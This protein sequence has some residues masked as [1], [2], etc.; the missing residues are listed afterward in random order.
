MPLTIRN[1]KIMFFAAALALTGCAPEEHSMQDAPK[2]E[3]LIDDIAA[4]T[5]NFF[6]ET[7][8]PENGL[9]PDRYP[10]PSFSSI[11]AVGYGLTAYPIGVERGFIS[12]DEAIDRTLATLRFFHTAPQGPE[13]RGNSGYK[14]FF[15][16]FLDMKTGERFDLTEL[17]TVDTA[18]LLGGVLFAQS[19]FDADTPREAEIRQL[20]EEIY[21]RTDWQWAMARPPLISLGWHPEKGFIPWD[22]RGYNEAMLVYILALGSPT[23]GIDEAAWDEWTS[24]Y[25]DSWGTLYGQSYLQFPSQFGHQYSHIWI[26]F[27]GIQDAYMK[28]KGIDYFEN[29]LR[30]TY[31]QRTYASANPMGWTAYGPNVWGITASDGPTGVTLEF[32]GERREFRAYSAR[33]IGKGDHF[34][35]GTLA[36][37][38]LIASLPFAPEIVAP[39]IV[40]LHERFGAQI[41]GE[42]GFLDA[43]NPSFTFDDVP[44]AHGRVIPGF[45]WV[46]DDYLGIDQGPILAMIENHESGMVWEIMRKNPHIRRGLKRAGFT[47]D[48]LAEN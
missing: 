11:A 25:E 10:S 42:Y 18:L 35:D 6:W 14:G 30:A 44:L 3:A 12:R 32:K 8:N 37:T 13:A 27:R 24:T 47:G 33:G 36:P 2:A 43:F 31:A 16:H 45:G 22:W 48:W 28:A 21:A 23:H 38:A 34:D 4:R 5:F 1:A 40:A 9:V 19:Y 17:S 29:S 20:A 26:D 46:A 39:S 41:Y 15:Y 7:S